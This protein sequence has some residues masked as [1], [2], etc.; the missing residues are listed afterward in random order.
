MAMPTWKKV[1]K[2]RD[3]LYWSSIR[4]DVYLASLDFRRRQL[5]HL[6]SVQIDDF[7][8][9]LIGD[10]WTDVGRL[11][12]IGLSSLAR[13]RLEQFPPDRRY[14]LYAL[15]DGLNALFNAPTGGFSS[16]L[17]WVL[18]HAFSPRVMP[19]L[20]LPCTTDPF[21]H[22]TVSSMQQIGIRI[23]EMRAEGHTGPLDKSFYIERMPHQPIKGTIRGRGPWPVA[24]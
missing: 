18:H 5:A 4:Q 1:L 3:A 10:V 12:R 13:Q 15:T 16:N 24:L 2:A 7:F 19:P 21:A 9:F 23:H 11:D 8:T 22:K 20:S 6:L 17:I 14:P